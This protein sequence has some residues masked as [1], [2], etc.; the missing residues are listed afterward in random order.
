MHGLCLDY[1]PLGT[2][3]QLLMGALEKVIKSTLWE[4]ESNPLPKFK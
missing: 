3:H 1:G 2:W 4:K